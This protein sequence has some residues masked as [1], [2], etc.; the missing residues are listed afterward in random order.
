MGLAPL[1]P[2]GGP[3]PPGWG[4]HGPPVFTVAG[5][6]W[7]GSGQ[8]PWGCGKARASGWAP[9]TSRKGLPAWEVC[10]APHEKAGQRGPHA[11]VCAHVRRRV[12]PDAQ[13]C[14]APAWPPEDLSPSRAPHRPVPSPWGPRQHPGVDAGLVSG[15]GEPPDPPWPPAESGLRDTATAPAPWPSSPGTPR[16]QHPDL[17]L[18][19]ACHPKLPPTAPVGPQA[20]PP[21]G[22]GL[23]GLLPVRTKVGPA[24]CLAGGQP[25]PE[26]TRSQRQW[27]LGPI[28]A[29]H[30]PRRR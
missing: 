12:G 15:E 3:H 30:R 24:R 7:G 25:S 11:R 28:S 29:Q 5:V 8:S 21:V 2:L 20:A 26:E 22:S 27:G 14:R 10:A 6:C 18:R 16:T 13:A 1:L 4:R 23:V 9:P 19:W 17:S